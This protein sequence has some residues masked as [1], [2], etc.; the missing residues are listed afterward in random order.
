MSFCWGIFLHDW[1][2]DTCRRILRNSATAC[3]TE[4]TAHQ[5]IRA[6]EDFAGRQSANVK[7]LLML[8]A[9]EPDARERTLVE[10]RGSSTR[11][12]SKSWT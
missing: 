3:P 5:R 1:S 8:V 11:R 6:R 9:N 4:A 10:Y 7:D 12:D 2:D